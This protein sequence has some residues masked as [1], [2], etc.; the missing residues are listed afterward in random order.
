MTICPRIEAGSWGNPSLPVQKRRQS[1]TGATGIESTFGYHKPV[2]P[3]GGLHHAQLLL[4]GNIWM[5]TWIYHEIACNKI[6][7]RR[8]LE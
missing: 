1:G 8:S 6:K 5:G 2:P 7:K 3:A 4:S